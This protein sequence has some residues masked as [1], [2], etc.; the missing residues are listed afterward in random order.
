MIR[1]IILVVAVAALGAACSPK[2]S[3]EKAGE[4]IQDAAKGEKK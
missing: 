3:A 4:N 1:P 2:G